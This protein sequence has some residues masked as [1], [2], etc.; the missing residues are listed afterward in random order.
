MNISFRKELISFL[1]EA[2]NKGEEHFGYINPYLIGE[3]VSALS[4]TSPGD[5]PELESLSDWADQYWGW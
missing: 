2:S 5:E 3:I 4:D 1:V